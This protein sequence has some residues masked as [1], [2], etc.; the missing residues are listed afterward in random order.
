MRDAWKSFR[1]LTE[2]ATEIRFLI[3]RAFDV[4]A[5]GTLTMLMVSLNPEGFSSRQFSFNYLHRCSS[6]SE[7]NSDQASEMNIYESG[8]KARKH[9][10]KLGLLNCEFK[11]KKCKCIQQVL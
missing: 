1:W 3:C 5:G 2:D 9:R 10:Q 6:L 7:R 8:P 4:D 11:L